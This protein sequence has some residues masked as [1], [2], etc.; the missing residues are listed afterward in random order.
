MI[1]G[2]PSNKPNLPNWDGLHVKKGPICGDNRDGY[3]W[4][5]HIWKAFILFIYPICS[6]IVPYLPVTF[7][8]KTFVFQW[9]SHEQ[10]YFIGHFFPFRLQLAS[11]PPSPAKSWNTRH[12]LHPSK[13]PGAQ[14]SCK[15]STPKI[16]T[17]I[18]IYIYTYIHIHIYICIYTY[19]HIYIYTY[20]YIHIYIYTYV[21]IY[22]YTHIHV[23]ILHIHTHIHIFIH[24]HI[25][26]H[27]HIHIY[28]HIYI[29][30]PV[31]LHI[32][33]IFIY[34]YSYIHLF[35]YS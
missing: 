18:H 19:M 2:K 10:L 34:I 5:Y 3:S 12:A 4:P 32:H 26:I 16:S 8:K 23:Y 6:Y 7:P 14:L 1:C 17:H 27:M 22:M 29:H 9:F 35:I 24:I 30:I 33:N 20:A 21:H 28:I 31:H 11:S 25:H 15:W 13:R